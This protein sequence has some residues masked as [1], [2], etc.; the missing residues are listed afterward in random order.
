MVFPLASSPEHTDI[1]T[2][3]FI[4]KYMPKTIA[5]LFKLGRFDR[6]V[7]A[8]LTILPGFW[9]LTLSSPDIN[10][11]YWYYIT[12]FVIGGFIARAAGCTV[13]DLWDRE[14]DKKVDRTA[15]RPLPSGQISVFQALLFL[16][17]LL[18]I[19]FLL[20][21]QL[22]FKAVA[23]GCFAILPIAIYPL[24]KR[25]TYWPQLFLGLVFNLSILIG[26]LC[27]QPD[28]SINIILVYTAAVFMTVG[29]DTIY[30]YQDIDDDLQVGIKSTAILCRE[31]PKMFVGSCYAILSLLLI[32]AYPAR[33]V[34]LIP[35]GLHLVWQIFAWKPQSRPNSL[36]IFKSNTIFQIL[37]WLGLLLSH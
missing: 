7:G 3:G 9:G 6:P 13:N 11:S 18:L 12:I 21:L 30:A 29:Y 31:R 22:P 25:I 4:D 8:W 24:M 34:Y 16:A 36:K 28:L 26:Y 32:A 2:D 19:G 33:A 35:A 17:L 37:V 10:M 27:F 15:V 23:M 5:A 20:L 1:R 14:L